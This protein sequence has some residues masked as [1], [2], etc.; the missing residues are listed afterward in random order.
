MIIFKV[1]VVSLISKARGKDTRTWESKCGSFR[2][3]DRGNFSSQVLSDCTG[4]INIHK[5][6]HNC[7]G[8]WE[9]HVAEE[10][11]CFHG[12]RRGGSFLEL[13]VFCGGLK[14]LEGGRGTH[15]S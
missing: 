3:S 8:G 1:S 7:K 9:K 11:M 10:A 4:R 5:V 2:G 12:R 6:I 13:L 14:F 15:Q